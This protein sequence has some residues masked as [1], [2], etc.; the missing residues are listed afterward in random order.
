MNTTT[1]TKEPKQTEEL[2]VLETRALFVPHEQF[3]VMQRELAEML[4]EIQAEIALADAQ[5]VNNQQD[6]EMAG[7]LLDKL[8]DR[9]KLV[10]SKTKPFTQIAD[11]LHKWLTRYQG[12]Y[13]S[14]SEASYEA[15]KARRNKWEIRVRQET[16]RKQAEAQAEAD[17]K[18][19]EKQA[20]IQREIERKEQEAASAKRTQTAEKRKQEIEELKERQAA[21]V[22]DVIH[23]EAPKPTGGPK[24]T[25][26]WHAEVTDMRSFLEAAVKDHT[27]H[28]YIE[29]KTTA[30]QMNKSRNTSMLIPGIR[31]YQ[32]LH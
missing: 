12:G 5:M 13:V 14:P 3:P 23:Y 11:K 24:S 18:T 28:G 27:L 25:M 8:A 20:A 29:V 15:L 22:P 16:E 6:A 10:K 9:V 19:R 7:V 1:E 32:D 26:R 31:F 4:P 30:M 21:I 2:A 17:R